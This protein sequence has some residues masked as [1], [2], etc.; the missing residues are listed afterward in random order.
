MRRTRKS[1]QSQPPLLSPKA[2]KK[3]MDSPI[4]DKKPAGSP[5]ERR[6]TASTSEEKQRKQAETT[7]HHSYRMH[8]VKF[9]E[10]EPQAI[11][12]IACDKANNRLAVSR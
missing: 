11:N 12:C 1:S 7:Q 9:F 4:S 5:R 2:D 10:Y 3:M 8:R 6:R